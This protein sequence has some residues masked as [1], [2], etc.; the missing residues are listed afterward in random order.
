VIDLNVDEDAI[1]GNFDKKFRYEVRRA[2]REGYSA[3]F[4]NETGWAVFEDAFQGYLAF[5][6][7]KNLP[8]IPV[9]AL[10][11]YSAAGALTLATAMHGGNP[12]QYHIYLS[13]REEAILLGS[14]VGPEGATAEDKV[15]GWANRMLHWQDMRWFR[16]HGLLRYNL[17][18]IGNRGSRNNENIIRFKLEMAPRIDTYYHGIVSATKR[19]KLAQ[20]VRTLIRGN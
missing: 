19:A 4:I 13:D 12:L 7:R 17:G 20:H 5:S 2:E 18:G 14:F 6:K 3:A 11:M 8:I 16:Q 9:K 1:F 10:R 15:T